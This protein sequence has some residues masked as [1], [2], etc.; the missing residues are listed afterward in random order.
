MTNTKKIINVALSALV[1]LS[2]SGCVTPKS[3][4]SMV[5]YSY[6]PPSAGYSPTTTPGIESY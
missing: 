6:V 4:P 5:D 1:L 2:V 3:A